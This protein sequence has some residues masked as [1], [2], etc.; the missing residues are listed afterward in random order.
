MEEQTLDLT[1]LI[2]D[3]INSIFFKFFSSIDNTIYS[4]LDS[5]LF[6][7]SDI[8]NNLKLQQ[9]FGD[10][11]PNGLL[12]IVKSLIVGLVLFYV[13]NF[14]V[15]H[16]IYTKVDS[17]YQFIFK[18]IIF[19]SCS[20]SSFW[21]CSQAIKFT[22]LITDLIREIGQSITGY[23][24]TFANLIDNIN[25]ALY[26]SLQIFDILSFDGVLKFSSSLILIYILI[27]YSIRY[28]MCI[29]LILLSPFSFLSLVNNTFDGFFKGWSKQ[30]FEL[31]FAQILVSILLVIAF[32]IDFN[33]SDFI[34]KI[35]YFSILSII[36]KLHYNSN[37][38]FTVIHN[39]SN[40]KL[41][42][43]I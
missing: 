42:D 16:L 8:T 20:Y 37:S 3:S 4:N 18:C 27:T 7:N 38:F 21:L 33:S 13:L 36:A 43:I 34:S 23:E 2:C 24:I 6:I 10:N 32:C 11:S 28:I 5:I 35:T 14:A 30:F 39:Y 17:P 22:S 9:F 12:I 40:N 26:T 31:L 1:E 41:K 25:S 15:S 29:L 19:I